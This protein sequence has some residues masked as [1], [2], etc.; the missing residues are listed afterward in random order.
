MHANCAAGEPPVG[1][2]FAGATPNR[3]KP[4][5][6]YSTE[7]TAWFGAGMLHNVVAVLGLEEID[8]PWARILLGNSR[9][10]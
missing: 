10:P 2:A 1:E 6:L 5:A 4:C 9:W 3:S 7:T 8:E